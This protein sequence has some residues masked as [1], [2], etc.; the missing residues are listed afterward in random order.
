[1]N[2]NDQGK[3]SINHTRIRSE[4]ETFKSLCYHCATQFTYIICN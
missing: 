1:L 2:K 3:T 4:F